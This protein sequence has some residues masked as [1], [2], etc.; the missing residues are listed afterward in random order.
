MATSRAVKELFMSFIRLYSRPL[1]ALTLA[2]GFVLLADMAEAQSRNERMGYYRRDSDESSRQRM[3][4]QFRADADRMARQNESL[5]NSYKNSNSSSSSGSSSSSNSNR[6]SSSGMPGSMPSVASDDGPQSIESTR[7]ETIRVRE[8]EA[9]TAQRILR[10]AAQGQPEAMWNAGRLL[11]TGG[12]GG[13]ARNDAQAIVW[14][15]KAAAAGHTEAATAL[16]ESYLFGHGVGKDATQAVRWLKAGAEGGVAR[17]QLQYGFMLFRGDGGLTADRNAAASW[18]M[19]SSQGGEKHAQYFVADELRKGGMWPK[20]PAQARSLMQK[21]ADQEQPLAMGDLADMLTFGEGG[22]KDLVQA[23][24]WYLRAAEAGDA[25]SK[26]NAAM[27]LFRG[28]GGP[29]D[30]VKGEALLRDAATRDGDTEAQYALGARL[31]EG[32]GLKQNLP[33]AARWLEQAAAKGHANA[34]GLLG[35]MTVHQAG[36]P[37][38]VPRALS[39]M[40]SG[41]KAGSILAADFLGEVLFLGING[42]KQDFTEA[43]PWNRAAAEGGR[44]F[45]QLR[46]GYQLKNGLGTT[47]N[48]R[49]AYR[50][51]KQARDNGLTQADEYLDPAFVAAN[52]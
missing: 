25:H 24:R 33:E 37:A 9:E 52:R 17:A 51:L 47:A 46:W 13:V 50:W 15:T 26:N 5:R 41:A 39:L 7:T 35:F 49:E 6:R 32:A 10:E 31:Y 3:S 18:L 19:K 45:A 2:L 27:M 30:P 42:V 11:F 28:E 48:G 34:Q 40:R 14:I 44:H 36:V 8:T 38:D 4:Q 21:A 20:D 22:P 23:R 1:T 12:Y 43:A 29:V 16:G